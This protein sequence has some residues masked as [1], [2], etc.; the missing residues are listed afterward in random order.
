MYISP[1]FNGSYAYAKKLGAEKVYILSAKHGL[2]D[3]NKIIE[4]YNE[5]LLKKSKQELISWANNVCSELNIVA[6]PQTDKYIILAGA[7]YRK[8]LIPHLSN[9]IIPM[10]NVGSIGKQLAFLKHVNADN[11]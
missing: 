3:E 1:L 11:N 8:Y 9:Y 10:E 2:L 4:P 7:V 6:D 5:T